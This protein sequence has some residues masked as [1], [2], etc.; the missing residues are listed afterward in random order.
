MN[1]NL[2]YW[3]AL[4]KVEGLGPVKTKKLLEQYGSAKAICEALNC[5]IQDADEELK[6]IEALKVRAIT[7]EDDAYPQNLKNIYDPP[8]ILFVKGDLL[9]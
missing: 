4:N 1:E 5:E 2:K 7:A 8:P 3:L 9:R 6:K